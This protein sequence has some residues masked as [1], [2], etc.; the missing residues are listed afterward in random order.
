MFLDMVLYRWKMT[1]MFAWLRSVVYYYLKEDP[2]IIWVF[3][4]L[5]FKS[6][7]L[8]GD[9][10]DF[11]NNLT[12]TQIFEP[13]N[14]RHSNNISEEFPYEV[15]FPLWANFE[16]TLRIRYCIPGPLQHL[17]KL[18]LN[19]SA[20]WYIQIKNDGLGNFH[21]IVRVHQPDWYNSVR[22]GNFKV[23]IL[24][25][26]FFESLRENQASCLPVD[27][28]YKDFA[29]V[30]D[31]R[32][33]WFDPSGRWAS[34]EEV[35]VLAVVWRNLSVSS[36]IFLLLFLLHL[37]FHFH[38]NQAFLQMSLELFLYGYL[39]FLSDVCLCIV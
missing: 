31:H 10:V 3:L 12:L 16:R 24:T 15:N 8:S 4:F 1:K 5:P 7:W 37:F 35:K 30:V 11:L 13:V 9:P 22:L 33:I 2:F 25:S 6:Y 28:F 32:R 34:I 19:F 17:F 26:N 27:F 36:G 38:F 18:F 21:N 20:Q 29:D 23:G 14:F 39:E